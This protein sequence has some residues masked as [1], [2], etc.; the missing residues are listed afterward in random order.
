MHLGISVISQFKCN[1]FFFSFA[2][3]HQIVVCVTVSCVLESMSLGSE[4][5]KSMKISPDLGSDLVP[6]LLLF[7][8]SRCIK[9]VTFEWQLAFT[10]HEK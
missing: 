4:G 10:G 7:W 1:I 6:F 5:R 9:I 2:R 8:Q 3:V